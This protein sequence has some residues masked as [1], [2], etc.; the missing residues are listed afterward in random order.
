MFR[1]LVLLLALATVASAVAACHHE[2]PVQRVP[3]SDLPPLPPSSGTP[4][5]Y[6]IDASTDLKLSSVQLEHLKSID[7]SLAARDSEIDAQLRQLAAADPDQDPGAAAKHGKEHKQPADPHAKVDAA[8]L[9]QM[10]DDNDRGAIKDAWALLDDTQ[11][12][13]AA[14]ILQAHDVPVPGAPNKTTA[15][16]SDGTPLPPEP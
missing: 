16:T 15:D 14:K 12:T 9:H 11:R 2:P 1:R 4:V 3:E 7:T 8:K 5:G 13:E 6:L 10:R